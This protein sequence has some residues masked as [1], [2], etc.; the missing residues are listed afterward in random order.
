M[1]RH[2]V[3]G[4]VV[5]EVLPEEVALSRHLSEAKD[6]VMQRS[7]GRVFFLVEGTSCAVV[8]VQGSTWIQGTARRPVWPE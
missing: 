7:K 3:L 8:L 4:R 6:Y 1:G 2:S 5:I